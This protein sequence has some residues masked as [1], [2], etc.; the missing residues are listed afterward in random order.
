MLPN[1]VRITLARALRSIVPLLLVVCGDARG[2]VVFV[3]KSS[4]G[5]HN[6]QTWSTGYL[7]IEDGINAAGAGAEVW[8][9]AGQYNERITLKSGVALYGGFL[10]TESVGDQR[11]VNANPTIIDAQAAGVVVTVQAGA[12]ASARLDGFVVRNGKADLG[13][14][15]RCSGSSP[16]ITNNVISG[17]VSDGYGG[18]IA[19]D[20]GSSPA[21]VNNLI[22]NNTAANLYGDGAGI[23]CNTNSNPL[24]YGNT[25]RGNIAT[26]NG[27][28]IAV[29][30]SSPTI[31]NNIIIDNLSYLVEKVF[32]PNRGTDRLS[33]GG[34]GILASERDM[35]DNFPVLGA[36]CNITVVNNVISANGGPFLCGGLG[37]IDADNSSPLIA[38]NTICSNNGAGFW[39]REVKHRFSNNIVAY[40]SAGIYGDPNPG[41]LV[42]TLSCNDVFGNGM[43]GV[44]PADY[45]DIGRQ[46]GYNGNL[47]ADP[48]LVSGMYGDYHIQPAS[49]CRNAGDNT[50]VKATWSDLDGQPR[51]L[52]GRVDIGAYESNGAAH[53][54]PS[55][56]FYVSTTG[57]DAAAGTT[58]GTAKRS[59]GAALAAA[60]L[61][62]GDV[63]VKAGTYNELIHLS[64]YT[65]LL[66]GFN[67]TETDPAQANPAANATIIDGGAKGS[68]VV[69]M[70][71]YMVSHMHGFTIRNGNGPD[72]GGGILCI[73]AGPVI[74]GNVVTGN[75]ATGYGG[76]IALYASEAIVTG[77]TITANNIHGPGAGLYASYSLPLV[78]GNLI[79]ANQTD[80]GEAGGMT[81]EYSYPVVADNEVSNNRG[82]GLHFGFSS[83]VIDG[84]YLH[85]NYSE[86]DTGGGIEFQFCTGR[87]A[88]NYLIHNNSMTLLGAGMGGA[89]AV[90]GASE[91]TYNL[92]IANNTI[93]GNGAQFGGG[94]YGGGI[95]YLLLSPGKLTIAN[96]IIAYNTGG[97]YQTFQDPPGPSAVLSHNLLYANTHQ[98]LYGQVVDQP[99]IF[100]TPGATDIVGRDPLFVSLDPP[101]PHLRAGSPAID[102]GDNTFIPASETDYDGKPRIIGDYADIGAYEF[103]SIR[104]YTLTDAATALRISA[105]FTN[106]T[107]STAIRM[108]AANSGGSFGCVDLWDAVL[109]L[110]KV[111]GL[112]PNP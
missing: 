72:R 64:P 82:G 110:R 7:T 51:T 81:F 74:Q 30:N 10:G 46:T 96:N 100:Q 24:I 107:L 68:V 90:F 69:A 45:G 71:G 13:G 89:I 105:G 78:Q 35:V 60:K 104:A 94:D 101:D 86:G 79:S 75:S 85:H 62:G 70:N 14:G 92:L 106:P 20:N 1:H 9:A 38:N 87:V 49:P 4:P 99:Y 97:I 112:A 29:W 28:G 31:A 23:C 65:R 39:W 73:A 47:S 111:A 57:N 55:P 103:G 84:N 25:I 22:T 6:G 93:A 48:L 17:N 77:N 2:A 43:P 63:W 88:N 5:P 58:W 76:G 15:I 53:A 34:G 42:S 108:N 54:V 44:A 52:E 67:G 32:D 98:D 8:V 102:K 41:T 37:V 50:A 56:R 40:N 21:I 80:S 36:R 61:A 19:C 95:G 91:G 12:D 83:V 27:G 66:G 109:I 33:I 11:N 3:N 59:I 16:T 26:Q 18:G